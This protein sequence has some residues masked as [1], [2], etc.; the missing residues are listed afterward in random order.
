M[1][2]PLSNYYLVGAATVLILSSAVALVHSAPPTNQ[3]PAERTARS[4][5]DKP[6]DES[7]GPAPV[8]DLTG[9]WAG[10]GEPALN[11]R[12]PP[13]TPEGQARLKLNI[14][15]PFSATSNDPWKTCDPF[16]MP[17]IVN[18]E[19]K[20]VGFAAMPDRVIILENYSKV[21][22]EVWTDGRQ[23]PKN[24]GHKGGSSTMYFGY[25]IGHWEG[26]NTFVV[27]TV[28]MDDKTWVDRRGYPHS[29]DAHVIE[30]YT[31]TDHNHM[32]FTE[33][34]DDPEYYTQPFMIAKASYKWIA[35]QDNLNAKI[36]FSAEDL[37]IPSQAIEYLRLVGAPADEDAVTGTNK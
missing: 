22:R 33:T 19:T 17:R 6:N 3:N 27:D 24:I 12:V 26:D 35:G 14:P 21:W 9:T 18:N 4:S 23:L 11:N 7:G 36:P 8:R 34:L 5:P 1:Q 31:R 16:G 28:G 25:S 29:V 2:N 15:D 10:P 32:N 37:C 30:R 13:M 20:E